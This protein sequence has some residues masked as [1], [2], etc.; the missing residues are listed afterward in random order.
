MKFNIRQENQHLKLIQTFNW[1]PI[2]V[3]LKLYN[4]LKVKNL[5]LCQKTIQLEHQV[6]KISQIKQI[7]VPLP[8]ARFSQLKQMMIRQQAPP[9]LF[10]FKLLQMICKPPVNYSTSMSKFLKK[11]NQLLALKKR[12]SFLRK[13]KLRSLKTYLKTKLQISQKL[14]KKSWSTWTHLNLFPKLKLNKWRMNSTRL[15]MLSIRAIWQIWMF[16]FLTMALFASQTK[17][18][19]QFVHLVMEQDLKPNQ[20][21]QALKYIIDRQ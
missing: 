2:V 9:M 10:R 15:L 8:Q 20:S 14:Q 18:E 5:H 17:M 21:K 4:C 1:N 19:N 12:M 13:L 11:K 7:Q 16:K 6:K 3:T